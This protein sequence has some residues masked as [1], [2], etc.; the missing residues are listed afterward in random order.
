[1]IKVEVTQEDIDKARIF[2]SM[3]CPIAKALKRAFNKNDI[4]VGPNYFVIAEEWMKSPEELKNKTE[5][6][7]PTEVRDFI[8]SFD[9]GSKVVPFTFEIDDLI[10]MTFVRVD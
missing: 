3:N 2:D 10:D 5:Y 6:I 7:L 1:M 4:K 8:L 9:C